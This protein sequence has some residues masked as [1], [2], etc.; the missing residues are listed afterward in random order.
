MN[1]EPHHGHSASS[2]HHG[3]DAFRLSLAIFVNVAFVAAEFAAG[4]HWR[5]TISA[6][7]EDLRCLCWLS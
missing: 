5:G 3:A 2:H 6:M 1:E 7:S 4:L